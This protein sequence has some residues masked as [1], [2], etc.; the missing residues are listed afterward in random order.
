MG[1]FQALPANV[2]GL[3]HRRG[4][5]HRRPAPDAPGERKLPEGYQVTGVEFV[6]EW[7]MIARDG[8]KIGYVPMGSLAKLQ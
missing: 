5:F 7:A 8:Q 3:R 1:R 4:P 6:G 2:Y